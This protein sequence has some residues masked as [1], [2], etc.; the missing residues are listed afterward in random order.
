MTDSKPKLRSRPASS[1]QFRHQE[2]LTKYKS[3]EDK[4]SKHR[5]LQDLSETS[6]PLAASQLP[7]P[8]EFVVF[9]NE[10]KQVRERRMTIED[11]YTSGVLGDKPA[12][13]SQFNSSKR[14]NNSRASS[15]RAFSRNSSSHQ[16]PKASI[17]T[18]HQNSLLDGHC[19]TNERFVRIPNTMPQSVSKLHSKANS[20]LQA[21]P[22][23]QPKLTSNL[24]DITSPQR[25]DMLAS[26]FS[27]M[28][29]ADESLS[30]LNKISTNS[31]PSTAS[32]LRK[33]SQNLSSIDWRGARER[34]EKK[35][36]NEYI[37]RQ[38]SKKTILL[39]MHKSHTSQLLPKSIDISSNN[40]TPTQNKKSPLLLNKED[41][42][43]KLPVKATPLSKKT[44]ASEP[45]KR[46]RSDPHPGYSVT[47]PLDQFISDAYEQLDKKDFARFLPL[48]LYDPEFDPGEPI[49]IITEIEK[50]G[51]VRGYSRWFFPDGSYEWRECFVTGYD[52]D[53]D[54]YEIRW[55]A[56]KSKLVS[57]MN[58]RLYY[59][60]PDSY[61]HRISE[62]HKY[63]DIAEVIMKYTYFIEAIK[64]PTPTLPI[65]VVD[66]ILKYVKG[67]SITLTPENI[68]DINI[69][70]NL[71]PS[72]R[73]ESKRFLWKSSVT[74]MQDEA[75]SYRKMGYD[76]VLAYK[77]HYFASIKPFKIFS[78]EFRNQLIPVDSIKKLLIEVDECFMFTNHQIDFEAD[79]PFNLKKQE[80][81]GDLLSPEKLIPVTERNREATDRLGLVEVL[82]IDMRYLLSSMYQLL[83]QANSDSLRILYKQNCQLIEFRDLELFTV[84]YI[85]PTDLER[86]TRTHKLETVNTIREL[87]NIMFDTQ[88][89]I[90]D[91]INKANEER[92][93]RN[94]E[95]IKAR[96]YNHQA[97]DIEERL[98]AEFLSRQHR[99]L[100]L[101]NN[102]F[103]REA[104]LCLERSLK[105]MRTQ[106]LDVIQ[107][108]LNC[109]GNQHT[110]IEEIDTYSLLKLMKNESFNK[111]NRRRPVIKC[112]IVPYSEGK[113]ARIEM[114]PSMHKIC[115]AFDD[116]VDSCVR[117]LKIIP[118]I[119]VAEVSMSHGRDFLRIVMEED[120]YIQQHVNEIKNAINSLGHLVKTLLRSLK[121]YEFV[122]RLNPNKIAK[123]YNEEFKLETAEEDLNKYRKAIEGI[124]TL[125]FAKDRLLCGVFHIK[126]DKIKQDFSLKL[127][128]ST[129]QVL[130]IITDNSKSRVQR[131]ESSENEIMLSLSK[132][133]RTLEELEEI[134][135]FIT[136]QLDDRIEVIQSE[137]AELMAN[138]EISEEFE[139]KLDWEL[140]ARSWLY[141]GLPQRIGKAKIICDRTVKRCQNIFAEELRVSTE[142]ILDETDNI[143]EELTELK[144]I[145]DLDAYEDTSFSFGVLKGRIERSIEEGR[146]INMREGLV[147]I[148]NTDFKQLEQIKRE[149]TPYCRVWFYARDFHYHFP[150]WM[151][152]NMSDLDRDAISE[153]VELYIVELTKLERST[154]KNQPA[155]LIIA[156]SLTRKVNDFKPYIPLIRFLRN[157]GLRD[158]HWDYIQSKTGLEIPKDLSVSLEILLERN[159]L[160]HIAIIEEVSDKAT[161]ELSLESAKLKMEREWNGMRFNLIA[162]KETGVYITVNNEAIWELLDDHI[163]KSI[164]ICG[165]PFI[166]FMEREMVI[167]K[168]GLI[169]LQDILT[170]LENLQKT[171]QYLQ[172]IFKSKDISKQL[173]AA[174][175][176]FNQ[177]NSQFESLMSA[178]YNNPNV[179]D[180]CLGQPKLLDQ[181]KYANETLELI[182]KSL[183]DYLN[184]KR[185]IFPRFYFLAN[186]E[187]LTI[188]SNSDDF[189]TIQR[190]IVKCFEGINN[191]VLDENKD[192]VAMQSPEDEKVRFKNAVNI[193]MNESKTTMKN[194]EEW[195]GD[196]EVEMINTLKHAA[197]ESLKDYS[198][199]NRLNWMQIG[200]S[201]IVHAINFSLWTNRVEEAV[202]QGVEAIHKLYTSETGRLNEIVDLVRTNLDTLPRLT[203][204]TSVIL[205]VHNRDVIQN[206]IENKVK[207]VQDFEWLAQLRYY[208]EQDVILV[209]M[210]DTERE[211]G[212]EYLGN[213][214]RLVITALTDRCYRTLM[215]ALRLN[216]GGAPEGPAGTGK[217][218]TTKDLAKSIGKKCLV[219][220]CSDR[221]DHIS[222]AKFFT[223]LCFC[224]A[225][226]CFDEFNRID[227]EVLSVVAEQIM[228]IQTAVVRKQKTFEFEEERINLDASCAIFITMNPGYAGRYELPDNLKALFRPVAMMIPEYSMIAEIYLYSYGF[229]DA[230]PLAVKLITSLRLSSEQLSTQ[231]H[232]DYGMRAVSTIVKAAVALKKTYPNEQE[233]I[234][235]LRAI[236]DSN[237]PKFISEDI[238]LFEGIV[239]D[240]FP[241]IEVKDQDYGA[242]SEEIDRVIQEMG[243][244]WKKEF[245]VKTLQIYDT[246][247]VR[248][249]LML[250]GKAMS[251][252]S[253]TIKILAEAMSR[254]QEQPKSEREHT[255]KKLQLKLYTINPK[256]VTLEQLYGDSDPVSHD[257]VDG[258][259]SY[260]IRKCADD[261]NPNLKW[262]VL[263]GPVD[264]H[265]IENMNTV[266]DD[267]KRLCLSSGEIIKLTPQMNLIFEVENL[268][269]ASPATVSRCGMIYLDNAV[270]GFE[271][272]LKKWMIKIPLAYDF[273]IY[274]ELFHELFDFFI[275][276]ALEFVF[277]H[278]NRAFVGL[279]KMWLVQNLL[280]LF[281]SMLLKNFNSAEEMAENLKSMKEKANDQKKPDEL[282]KQPETQDRTSSSGRKQRPRSK[283]DMN[284]ENMPFEFKLRNDAITS[285]DKAEIVNIFLFSLAWSFGG[286]GESEAR[287]EFS[288]FLYTLYKKSLTSGILPMTH[289]KNAGFTYHDKDAFHMYYNLRKRCWESWSVI[290]P[291]VRKEQ[292]ADINSALIP[293]LE[294][295]SY[296]YILNE[297]IPRGKNI[298]VTGATGTGKT[299]VMKK[300]LYET[301]NPKKFAIVFNT[302]TARSSANQS[303]IFIESKLSR[304]KKGLYGPEIGKKCV[305]MIDDLNMPS[306]E[307][308]GAQPAI[309]ILR[310]VIDKKEWYD[311]NTCDLK[312]LDDMQYA[313]AMG[314][315]GGGRTHITERLMHHFYLTNF[316]EF[317]S[318]SLSKIFSTILSLGLSDY[319]STVLN[320]ISKITDAAI[321]VYFHTVKDLPPTPAKSHYTFNLRDISRLFKAI[322][323]M[324]ASKL[325]KSE[326]L[327]KLW[328][329]ECLRVFSDRLI[330]EE[331]T[332]K[333]K[334]IVNTSMMKWMNTDY[335]QVTEGREPLFVTFMDDMSYC[336]VTSIDQVKQ[337][338]EVALDDYN[339]SSTAKM[340]LVLFEFAI[341]HIARIT[342]IISAP[343]GHALLIGVGG[344][345]KQSLS[346]LS[347]YVMGYGTFSIQ[348]SKLY[349]IEEW[350]DD[351]KKLVMNTGVENKKITFILRDTDIKHEAFIEN[352]NSLLN[353]GE[354]P[355]LHAPDEKDI[356][357]ENMR[358]QRGMGLKSDVERWEV[359]I[360]KCIKNLHVVLCMSP[361]GDTL[362][363]RLRQ[364][365]SL[366]NCCTID[367]FSEWPN[368]ALV[369][370]AHHF[371]KLLGICE[372]EEIEIMAV[373]TC[374]H[375][376]KTMQDLTKQYYEE[377][378]RYNYVTPTNYLQLLS[379]IKQILAHKEKTTVR[380]KKK[381]EDGVKRLDTTQEIV[382]TL[383]TELMQLK[384]VL[385][386]KTKDTE[387]IMRQLQEENL[388]ADKKRSIVAAQ[389]QESAKE[390]EFS[391]K[392]KQE[393]EEA[394]AKAIPELESA[395]AA[396]KTIKKEHIH[397]VK[398][399][400]H[401]PEPI[402]L[403]VEA[404]AI[405]NREKP[406]KVNDPEKKGSYIYDY[407]EAGKRMMNN[408]KFIK[409]LEIYDRD[410]LTQD[411]I[412]QVKPYID[413]PRFLPHIVKNAS[414]AA[415]GLCKW[416][417]AMYNFYHINQDIKPKNA[418]LAKAKEDMA[419]RFRILQEKEE[420][421]AEIV[422]TIAQLNRN[423]DEK[424]IEKQ[425][426]ITDVGK[427]EIKMERA[428]RLIEKLS[429]EE[430][431]WRD[432]VQKLGQDM[433][434]LL[435]DVILSAG[436][437]SYLGTF[438]G[439]YRD[440]IITQSWI[441]FINSRG[442]LPCSQDFSLRGVL[443][444]PLKIQNWC[445]C[446][447]PSDKVS[448][449]NAIIMEQTSRWPLI[450]DPQ[451][452]ANRWIRKMMM[453]ENVQ[454]LIA[455]PSMEELLALLENALF[456]GGTL[457]IESIGEV[458]DPVLEPVLLKQTFVENGIKM[459]KVGDTAKQ[460]DDKFRLFLS[461]N[462]PNPHYTPEISTK[463]TILNFTIT[464][465]GLSENL[466]AL[467]CQ[468]ELPRETEERNRLIVQS[469]EYTKRMQDFEDKIL[470]MLQVSA[471]EMLNDEELINSL[472]ESKKMS[473]EV[474]KKL[475]SAKA[476][477]KR[478]EEYQFNYIP[479]AA[480]SA[481]LYFC[482][483]DL[484]NIEIM[485][486]YS[487]EWFIGLFRRSLNSAPNSK[488]L[489]TRLQNLIFEF[490]RVL[491]ENITLSLYE[492]D[493]LLFSFIMAV[494]L[495]AHDTGMDHSEWKFLLAG[496][497]SL[498][499]VERCTEPNPH[500]DFIEDRMWHEVCEISTFSNFQEFWKIV[501]LQPLAWERFV[502]K[503]L[504]FNELPDF[505]QFC[506]NIPEPYGK[507]QLYSPIAK[508]MLIRVF[509][510]EDM[511]S[512]AR[513]F[514]KSY[515]GEFY[516]KPPLFNLEKAYTESSPSTPLIF[517]LSPG[518]DP[519]NMLKRFAEEKVSKLTILSLGKGQ[520]DRA[521]K[522][523]R[524]N[525]QTGGW[526]LL[527]NCHLAASWMNSLEAIIEK[528]HSDSERGHV[529]PNF[530]LW[531][532]SRP[533]KDFPAN[534]LQNG[535]KLTSE[536]PKG[537]KNNLMSIYRS[538]TYSKEESV[539]YERTI[540]PD[541]WYKLL[542]GLTFFHC[543]V[544]ERRKFGPL[545]WN[546][547]YEFNESDLRISMRQLKMMLEEYE[548]VPYKA[549]NYLAG[550]CNY[551]GKVT[552][553]WDRRTLK[554]LLKDFYT[555]DILYDHY[556]FQNLPQYHIPA[557]FE[558]MQV[559]EFIEKLPDIETPEIFGLHEN[560]NITFARK[561]TFDL[562]NRIIGLQPRAS[563]SRSNEKEELQAIT[564]Q[565]QSLL[566]DPFDIKSI[567][568]KYPVIYEQ[569]MNTVLVQEL[570]RYNVLLQEIKKSL[571]EIENAMSGITIISPEVEEIVKSLLNNQI[572]KVW[573]DVSYPS[574]KS[575]IS[576][577][578]D[579][580]S[581]INFFRV[582]I[583]EGS[584]TVYWISGF[585]F[586]QAFLTGT[587]QNYAR[588]KGEPIDNLEFSFEVLDTISPTED[589]KYSHIKTPPDGC[590]IHGLFLEGAQWDSSKGTLNE[591]MP[592]VLFSSMPMIWL[593]P[594]VKGKEACNSARNTELYDCPVYRTSKR[595]GTLSTT[596]HSTN[597]V[598]AIKIP[599]SQYP[600]HW[601]K[602][603]VALL[604]QLDD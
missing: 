377:M 291:S 359:F 120:T 1:K 106:L 520:G 288:E 421:L 534:I 220:N 141:Y 552:D 602:R 364:F 97:I 269:K 67:R 210:I 501:K 31:R 102:I 107:D 59:E 240:L 80:M 140:F 114:M 330:N 447:L 236:K 298:L 372:D 130:S 404:T 462:L 228:T 473:E 8:G 48:E 159:I 4:Q 3:F 512:A 593:K 343:G 472:T 230:R 259:L 275:P 60:D 578:K 551:G 222:M 425:K 319:P 219:F 467:V 221:L 409:K 564:R 444:E 139:Y 208:V 115:E 595:A 253:S 292:I 347:S 169:R 278:N 487:M 400:L 351:M 26:S 111:K 368:D 194:I 323:S 459:L 17:I 370:V 366:V 21:T 265:W 457:L 528:L 250:V 571:A 118:A 22:T 381:Y 123:R 583:S 575:L 399:M 70:L 40:T 95:R 191:L 326:T 211:Y 125:F 453:A 34:E 497:S 38:P 545:G 23:S 566:H 188:L 416:V 376:H 592:N 36:S 174:S 316:I 287:T 591:A 198:D 456:V 135:H 403:A 537:L 538:I 318:E 64:T 491:F 129:E 262:V 108:A 419:E 317:T 30:K 588:K 452:Q 345:G 147:G 332:A 47:I 200:P 29:V 568:E 506:C 45:K 170:E 496:I 165:S 405:L 271:L 410:S 475:A 297:L 536:P 113:I 485:Y 164:S 257:W 365:P 205:D 65:L 479:V 379:N 276:P 112:E 386:E 601:I 6:H 411:V 373:D 565:I 35:Q 358:S 562:F 424:N 465:E 39:K 51:Y 293:T 282:L 69:Y 433:K 103:E 557:A 333:F 337:T 177:I 338:L 393:C 384:P 513:S 463:V 263:D 448:I 313:G 266:L 385:E 342:R 474:E 569:S 361:V 603:G 90:Q 68:R 151:K 493:K 184:N 508:M 567:S 161:R 307:H 302:Y 391:E 224:G 260:I 16:M 321:D 85:K 402:K 274:R 28:T 109:L 14:D 285:S 312:L 13:N 480:K 455:K 517:I 308:Y 19:I 531:L 2:A 438:M 256:A 279:N 353:S 371:V 590:Y 339:L 331:D 247:N 281:E 561:E 41:T 7:R 168:N 88:Y 286:I 548:K 422:K 598:M 445:I 427:C 280:N 158:R 383:R 167:W 91:I 116:I 295:V 128:R 435:G 9:S 604:T 481:V 454:L 156:Q 196:V 5:A 352:I 430:T 449:E 226:A 600:T 532:T 516:L 284:F 349:E 183:N 348:I 142:K 181:L 525:L 533:S 580:N 290:I 248:H 127:R 523:I 32:L 58:L 225:W 542:F 414:G 190:Y 464:Q 66:Q 201:Q 553:D 344:S 242:L 596:G 304:R 488:D 546:V 37:V 468:K 367:W 207:D 529:S 249:G 227:L 185:R 413:H 324:P 148:K 471:E 197:T 374:V 98:P 500:P 178:I 283:P 486:Q 212:Y 94:E 270:V 408:P 490:R 428:V 157:P 241:N 335:S 245:K 510:P 73:Y 576:W 515:I 152:G 585:F 586:T 494:R 243:L 71:P 214:G 46:E 431:R 504:E 209:R 83:H 301:L 187:L 540:K 401:P 49:K 442:Y 132:E 79:I 27:A 160:I 20:D 478:I 133:P 122:I 482:V 544:R 175:N 396:L 299:V 189:E 75:V 33:N 484:S 144:K 44:P 505:N 126:I 78:H 329:H 57:R 155:G 407:F 146:V 193:F 258:V 390:A 466:L 587:L 436:V 555:D 246:I 232:Y 394:L 412:E 15:R 441:P 81:F 511:L 89:E 192:V 432:Q 310:Q 131:L 53:S 309:E 362:R 594:G 180:V 186:D 300:Y 255:M 18:S 369:N 451:K 56:S 423:F 43:P 527:Q 252:K 415:E 119:E 176:R 547:Y 72:I 289:V 235:I 100:S 495:Y 145:K 530:R 229:R 121:E 355:N 470:N 124:N 55:N 238:P 105:T 199:D 556:R 233:E 395:I 378:K 543:V 96:A 63:R 24:R 397:L 574:C 327:Y 380:L 204:G 277:Q 134:K 179:L 77:Q 320:C 550:E 535:V 328:L 563:S 150:T 450:I 398:T 50:C 350:Q 305:V 492:K 76:S 341:Y 92:N 244:V 570:T 218:E 217:T 62:A 84:I 356:I 336:E 117:D 499:D 522:I 502:K 476:T 237:L 294:T 264:A 104:R 143:R 82:P 306:K 138:M 539:F 514:V 42:Y 234:L 388:E 314:P 521:A 440:K 340:S 558:V 589:G 296:N 519:A 163:M 354:I 267:N 443:G 389:Q 74:H 498:N 261:P 439:S 346:R 554:Y 458:I 223:G 273:A 417:R 582:W 406:V 503:K 461:T 12:L 61:E 203:L 392:I 315:P 549:L 573:L 426:L 137:I 418:A 268:D 172:P 560:A 524:E 429:G 166:E 541:E 581:R 303:Q 375:F 559:L 171:W 25:A 584:P 52:Q 54:R 363:N 460:Y 577:A 483:S 509:K 153:E 110:S 87:R 231:S 173:P 239:Q 311:F 101:C 154:F 477:E 469:S 206:L 518:N 446:G 599:T 93:R 99:L 11:L 597:Y 254:L 162:Y 579:L 272:L 216:L 322:M 334:E 213:Q 325:Y 360:N 437:V 202:R 382:A 572:P 507:S 489:E 215:G 387:D 420:E 434:N 10:S 136:V 357:L 86:I 149:F 251:G 526:V 195:L 182:H